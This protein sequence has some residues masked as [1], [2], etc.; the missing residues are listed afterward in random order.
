VC[1]KISVLMMNDDDDD[2]EY[3]RHLHCYGQILSRLN[4]NVAALRVLAVARKYVTG[5][6]QVIVWREI[7]TVLTNAEKFGLAALCFARTIRIAT[8]LGNAKEMASVLLERGLMYINSCDYKAAEKDFEK[9]MPICEQLDAYSRNTLFCYNNLGIANRRLNRPDTALHF[10]ER[11]A[12]VATRRYGA[13][14]GEVATILANRATILCDEGHFDD[15]IAIAKR[16]LTIQRRVYGADSIPVA[17][18]LCVLGNALLNQ[19]RFEEALQQYEL[20][21]MIF[22]LLTHGQHIN[23]AHA[24][25][26]QR[27][28]EEAIAASK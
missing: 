13:E 20:A 14:S 19:Q 26:F 6:D 7:A 22:K 11:A 24:V 28:C 1:L 21:V 18:V 15:T 27:I 9:A 25:E 5:V 4:W 10:F 2:D 17:E 16:S 12:V 8:K 23:F 3:A